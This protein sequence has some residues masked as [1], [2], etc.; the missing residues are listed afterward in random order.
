LEAGGSGV[1]AALCV[2]ALEAGAGSGASLHAT[3]TIRTAAAEIFFMLRCLLF[4]VAWMLDWM[5]T[6]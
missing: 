4:A 2:S 6:L 1:G 5:A 3:S